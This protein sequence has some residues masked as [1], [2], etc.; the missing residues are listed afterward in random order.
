MNRDATST[1]SITNA[2]GPIHDWTMII[3]N[4]TGGLVGGSL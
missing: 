4:I 2:L 3:L 1:G